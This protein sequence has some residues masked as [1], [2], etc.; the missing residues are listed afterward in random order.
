MQG[1]KKPV[2]YLAQVFKAF[3]PTWDSMPPAVSLVSLKIYSNLHLTYRHCPICF[4]LDQYRKIHF[5]VTHVF[6]E[7]G[8]ANSFRKRYWAG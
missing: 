7:Q 1:I 8:L 5:A 2:S 4:N 3:R 6:T